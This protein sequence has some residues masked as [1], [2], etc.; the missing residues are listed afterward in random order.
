MGGSR[1]KVG[2]P[3]MMLGEDGK[4]E[5]R[6]YG[7]GQFGHMRGAAECKAGKDAIWG[8]APKAYLDKVERR[9]GKTPTGGKRS[10]AAESKGICKYWSEDGY[11]RWGDKCKFE[12]VGPPGGSKRT[13]MSKGKGGG[14]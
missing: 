3:V 11:C 7:C 5:K 4:A 14:K 9:F 6:C 13:N 1:N 8:G 10:L 2:H 12:H